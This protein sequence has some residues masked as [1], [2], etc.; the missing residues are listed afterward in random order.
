MVRKNMIEN[1]LGYR[2]PS[3]KD[4]WEGSS[5]MPEPVRK[6]IR[7]VTGLILG[8]NALKV[9]LTAEKFVQA[10]VS[11]AKQTIVVRSII[12]P[13]SN[14]SSNVMQLM[15]A[16]VPIRDIVKGMT[17]KMVE[18][19]QH[20]R[21]Q[22]RALEVKAQ[23]NAARGQNMSTTKLDAEL[24][25]LE[26]SD[27]RMSI[28]PLIEAGEFST[29]SETQTEIDAAISQ[30]RWVE[31]VQ[32]KLANV[33]SKL[34]TVGRYAVIT[35]DTAVFQGMSRA[36]QYGDF[37]A[38]AVLY[39][40][41]TDKKG[42]TKAK[43]IERTTEEFVNYN[44]V[45]GRTRSYLESMGVSWFWAFKI[46]SMKVA[47]NMIR[48]NPLRALMLGYGVEMAPDLPLVD[49][50]S[51]MGDNALSVILEGRAG[52]SIGP[53]MLFSAPELNPWVN[54]FGWARS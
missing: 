42:L 9:M 39:E 41:L 5:R 47:L 26:D 24:R 31:W 33:P 38:K 25:A 1:S 44:F 52:W 23:I 34:G 14:I 48:R 15:T 37:L 28:W 43:A 13:A 7:D 18:I 29:I 11:A 45:A 51:P 4:M 46:R 17:F 50:G 27:R 30:G 22:T 8:K 16:G 36:V 54:L 6:G 2:M 12:V 32:E 35:K 40:H 20:L 53:G 3:V 10:G 21:N 49:V 19:N